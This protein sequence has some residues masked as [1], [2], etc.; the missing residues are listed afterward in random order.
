MRWRWL[1]HAV[2]VANL[3]RIFSYCFVVPVKVTLRERFLTP[4]A[5]SS[6]SFNN[7]RGFGGGNGFFNYE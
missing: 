6:R 2:A 5:S 4:I 3:K 1:V 7:V